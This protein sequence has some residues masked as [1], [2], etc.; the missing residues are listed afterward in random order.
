MTGIV[1]NPKQQMLEFYL[2]NTFKMHFKES[3]LAFATGFLGIITLQDVSVIVTIFGV[4]I[5]TVIIPAVSG[6][7]KFK[8]QEE[9]EQEAAV[10]KA[11]KDLRELGFINKDEPVDEQR[12]K[13]IEWLSKPVTK[14]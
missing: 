3:M 11:I 1:P 5:G 13:A 2:Y 4:A 12:A 7:R 10:I 14:V 9:R 6:W 8:K